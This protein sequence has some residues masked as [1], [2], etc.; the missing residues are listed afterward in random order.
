MRIGAR[1]ELDPVILKSEVETEE[2]ICRR[3]QVERGV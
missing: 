1:R 3:E 2:G